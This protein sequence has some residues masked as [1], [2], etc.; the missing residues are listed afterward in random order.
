[1]S[2]VVT[3]AT[4]HLG[5]ATVES[6]LARGVP[7]GEIVAGGRATEK[8]KDLADRGVRVVTINYSD[9]AGLR[10]A[11]DGARQ[12]LLISGSEVGQR[13]PQHTNVIEA[14]TDAGVE[15]LAYTSAPYAATTSML[16][17]AEHKATEDVIR[18]SGLPF[19]LLR[20]GWYLEN[21]LAQLPTARQ[22]GVLY[23]AA[24]E[25]RIS[26]AARVDFA[27]AA[28]AV[29]A[30]GDHAGRT[31]ELGGDD[32]FTRAGLAAAITTASGTPVEYR[33][34]SQAEYEQILTDAGL[35]APMPAILADVERAVAAG[36]LFIDSGDLSRL[37]GRPTTT[38]A[39][40]LAATG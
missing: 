33:N 14:A 18:A 27:E 38:L 30:S 36:E 16:L 6:L 10:A 34:V 17:A 25:G 32:S 24:G 13:V 5:R 1:M 15:L 40:A 7:A 23:G 12:V 2:I 3:G 39:A 19:A 9:P 28:A 37:I 21:Y 8:I 29:L 26:A 4:G 11:L 31:Y 35:P 20:N 22:L